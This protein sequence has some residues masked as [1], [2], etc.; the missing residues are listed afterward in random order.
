[1]DKALLYGE[2]L[3]TVARRYSVSV[4]NARAPTFA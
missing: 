2:H 3:K 4:A 1:M